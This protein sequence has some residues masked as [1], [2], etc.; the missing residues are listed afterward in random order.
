MI[1][2]WTKKTKMYSKY[3]I[4][5]DDDSVLCIHWNLN[6]RQTF[7]QNCK[8]KTGESKWP[9]VFGSILC[10]TTRD[11]GSCNSSAVGFVIIFFI[12]KKTNPAAY[13]D[14]SRYNNIYINIMYR[15]YLP[16][17]YTGSRILYAFSNAY[18]YATWK[19]CTFDYLFYFFSDVR[20]FFKR[21]LAKL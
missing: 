15:V 21:G 19:V 9:R 1:Y 14:R 6:L 2:A 20:F 5:D 3:I 4:D 13:K 16:T 11:G 8:R 18:L 12:K 7:W 17:A 10:K